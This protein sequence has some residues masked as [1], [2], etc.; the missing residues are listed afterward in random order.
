[1]LN[2]ARI[3]PDLPMKLHTLELPLSSCPSFC[4]SS[5]VI[6]RLQT[7]RKVDKTTGP[8]PNR[9]LSALLFL[10]SSMASDFFYDP[11]NVWHNFG[12]PYV[13]LSSV[14]PSQLSGS[15]KEKTHGNP[16]PTSGSNFSPC[17]LSGIPPVCHRTLSVSIP[18]VIVTALKKIRCQLLCCVVKFDQLPSHSLKGSAH[19]WILF[20]RLDKRR[21]WSVLEVRQNAEMNVFIILSNL[22]KPEFG[23]QI[24][25][26]FAKFGAYLQLR[27]CLFKEPDTSQNIFEHQPVLESPVLVPL[28][29]FRLVNGTEWSGSRAAPR[30]TYGQQTISWDDWSLKSE[31]KK[32]DGSMST[33]RPT[34]ADDMNLIWSEEA[35]ISCI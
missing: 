24:D 23:R 22:P 25:G 35:T 30:Q 32:Q 8:L 5:S 7:N 21:M 14:Q 29:L 18:W 26:S 12:V 13:W 34:N 19:F 31:P 2:F 3:Q 27:S 1:M 10:L 16:W 9:G 33:M 28:G 17:F 11:K 15:E 20:W 4:P 6:R